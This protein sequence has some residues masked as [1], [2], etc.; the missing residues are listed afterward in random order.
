MGADQ[1]QAEEVDLVEERLEALVLRGPCA[2][3]GDEV[4]GNVNGAGLTVLLAG[5]VLGVVECAT[6]V[7]AALGPSA[8]MGV[9]RECGGQDGPAGG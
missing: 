7:A 6:V 8:A 5:N 1:G 2:Y 3:L 9:E 4:L